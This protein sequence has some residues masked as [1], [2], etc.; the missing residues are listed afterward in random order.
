M[1]PLT[2]KQKRILDYINEFTLE[3]GYPPSVRE[4]CAQVGLRSPSTVHNHIKKLR[5]LGYLERDDGRTRSLLVRGGAMATPRVP[6]LGNVKAGFPSIAIE[7]IE[8]Y[9]P[10]ENAKNTNDYFALRING[11]SMVGA[12]I[13]DGD[14]IIV[15]KQQTARNGQIVVAMI[16]D[17][18]TCKRLL[19]QHDEVWLMPENENYPPLN[20]EN[21]L[22]L[23]VVVAVYR[24]YYV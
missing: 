21:S 15:R 22:I 16:D 24:E 4:I 12:G 23:G 8:G 1:K 20:G 7:E 5:E 3:K 10:Y 17:E 6:I 2:D 14:L 11:E 13:L 18:T 9:I 19:L